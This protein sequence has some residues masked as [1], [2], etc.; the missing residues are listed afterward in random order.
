MTTRSGAF[1]DLAV[2]LKVIHARR[3]QLRVV[4]KRLATVNNV[5]TGWPLIFSNF[6]PG[7]QNVF[8]VFQSTHFRVYY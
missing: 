2:D 3:S 8:K 4:K 1:V 7:F 5:D 6:F